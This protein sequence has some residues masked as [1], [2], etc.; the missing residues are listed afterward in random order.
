MLASF[1]NYKP[2]RLD[3]IGRNWVCICLGVVTTSTV[4][5]RILV[6]S[7]LNIQHEFIFWFLSFLCVITK[8][9]LLFLFYLCALNGVIE[10]L[11]KSKQHCLS[12]LLRSVQVIVA[13]ILYVWYGT[14][15]A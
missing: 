10:R 7:R 13:C 9:S 1:R 8:W 5:G 3:S 12:T 15:A 11:F 2:S 6:L 4:S 14:S